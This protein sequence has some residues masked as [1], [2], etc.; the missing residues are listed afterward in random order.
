MNPNGNRTI[1]SAKYSISFCPSGWELAGDGPLC[2]A[3]FSPGMKQATD[4]HLK[5]HTFLGTNAQKWYMAHVS[6][7]LY[8]HLLAW[9]GAH[10]QG[11][12]TISQAHW[13]QAY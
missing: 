13:C 1:K 4:L 9:H 6:G 5:Y 12:K 8:V 10:S 2:T 7:M 11:N 3:M